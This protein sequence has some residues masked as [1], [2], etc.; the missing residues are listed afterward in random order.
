MWILLWGTLSWANVVVGLGLAVA[1]R[2]L[3]PLPR[4]PT[5]GRVHLPTLVR[6][7]AVVTWDL[8]SSSV[9]VLWLAL[10]VGPRVRS[11]VVRS[12]LQVRSNLVLALI[13]DTLTMVPGSMV[14]EIDQRRRVIHTH[15]LGIRDERD[16]ETFRR[17][18]SQL[19]DLFVGAFEAPLV[20]TE[21]PEDYGAMPI[22]SPERTR[23][24]GSRP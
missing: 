14:L 17:K 13:A 12:Q 11:A 9:Q 1:I 22:E 21:E 3:L 4:V 20:V 5:E 6:L 16:V 8:L 10:T 15:L 18:V 23:R 2:V 24:L 19:E 7:I